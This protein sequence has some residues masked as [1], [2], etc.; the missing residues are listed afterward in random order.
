[1]NSNQHIAQALINSDEQ[2]FELFYKMEF[3]N[4]VHFV[5]T[6]LDDTAMAKD[7]AQETFITLW[8]R[9]TTINPELNLRSYVF[10]IAKNK[11]LNHLRDNH[12]NSRETINPDNISHNY[13]ALSHHSV[14]GEIE[15]L[16]MDKLITNI[17]NKLQEPS[18][19]FFILNRFNGMSYGEIAEHAGVSIKVVEYQIKKALL[20]FRKKFKHYPSASY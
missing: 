17:C 9:R 14:T 18:R 19:T 20:F 6:Y 2:I 15:A 4:V 13:Q 16:E 10:T 3:N 8:N 5:A 1:M 7:I 11:T 12:L